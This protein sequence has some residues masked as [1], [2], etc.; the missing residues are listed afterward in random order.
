MVMLTAPVVADSKH[1]TLYD[2]VTVG[3]RVLESGAY[4]VTWL[5]SGPE[6]Q[7]TFS[8]GSKTVATTRARLVFEKSTRR[9]V[10][11][12]TLPDNS[13]VLT[14]LSF[15]DESLYFDVQ[16]EGEPRAD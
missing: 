9:A 10:Q 12:T 4:K 14:R 5:G 1:I 3:G 7:V 8:R 15:S 13:I 2:A 6:V 11:T 16:A